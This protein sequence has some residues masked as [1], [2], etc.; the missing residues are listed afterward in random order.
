VQPVA[1]DRAYDCGRLIRHAPAFTMGAQFAPVSYG[2]DEV[3][4]DR[5]R[6]GATNGMLNAGGRFLPVLPC[7]KVLES[8]PVV[9]RNI[10]H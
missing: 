9:G 4:A 7:N 8:Q 3:I 6:H 10:L 5:Y 2:Y 1:L